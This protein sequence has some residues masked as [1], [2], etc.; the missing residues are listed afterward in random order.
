MIDYEW[1]RE[2][3]ARLQKLKDEQLYRSEAGA[4]NDG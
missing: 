1:A 2:R 3:E 4:Q